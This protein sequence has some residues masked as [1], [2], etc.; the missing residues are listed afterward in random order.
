MSRIGRKII[1]V[2]QGVTVEVNGDVVNVSGPKGQLSQTIDKQIIVKQE[3]GII[4][5]ERVNETSDARAKH[6]LFR[7]LIN[8]MIIGV[9]EGYSKKLEIKGVGY[10][11][12][13]Q[14]NK[15]VL[16][17]GLSHP[18]EV[19]EVEG[20]TL[21]TP[22]QTEILVSGIDKQSV[23]Q[24]AAKIRGFRPVEPYHGYGIK[25]SDEVVIRK[26]GKTAGRK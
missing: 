19:E 2:P 1:T 24:M 25:Y 17:L 3:N 5:L 10:R 26:V 13:K 11:V 23:G 18:V 15:L 8:N 7:S 16:S 22:A 21:T 6:G 9:N 14:G 12:A 4:T 20:I